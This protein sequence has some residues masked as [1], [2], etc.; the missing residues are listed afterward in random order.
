MVNKYNFF[1]KFVFIYIK[2]TIINY[3]KHLLGGFYTYFIYIS[4]LLLNSF[5]IFYLFCI[6]YFNY[7]NCLLY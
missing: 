5:T 6:K 1:D 7:S 3:V 2:K 4:Y